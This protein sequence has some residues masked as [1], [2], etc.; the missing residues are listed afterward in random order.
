MGL[1]PV[2]G[3]QI[4]V[5]QE[6]LSP[7]TAVSQTEAKDLETQ[8]SLRKPSWKGEKVTLQQAQVETLGLP[9]SSVDPS[10]QSCKL[11]SSPH[12]RGDTC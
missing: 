11:L 12:V 10:C 3:E 2:P 9:V 4:S 7:P 5:L 1:M 8:K 6:T